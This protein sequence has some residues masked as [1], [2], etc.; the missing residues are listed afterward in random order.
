[1]KYLIVIVLVCSAAETFKLRCEVI[2]EQDGDDA[3]VVI[4]NSCYCANK[5][6]IKRVPT[7]LN[8]N[9]QTN[10]QE[11]ERGLYDY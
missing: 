9:I 3:G 10:N 8:R 11:K 6:D 1:M 4:N 2:C 5:R 7:R